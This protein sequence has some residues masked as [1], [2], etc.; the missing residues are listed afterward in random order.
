MR[1]LQIAS[2]AC[3]EACRA[4]DLLRR[5]ASLAGDSRKAAQHRQPPPPPAADEPCMD[6]V[7]CSG[8]GRHAARARTQSCQRRVPTSIT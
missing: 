2:D 6:A 1:L 7:T 8:H 4:E 5:A 3:G